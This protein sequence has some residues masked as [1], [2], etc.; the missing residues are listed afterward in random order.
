[1]ASRTPSLHMDHKQQRWSI[2]EGLG[3]REEGAREGK[4]KR[5]EREGRNVS[6]GGKR[7]KGRKEK[8][9]KGERLGMEQGKE[10]RGRGR[11]YIQRG[12][13]RAG[14]RR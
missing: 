11:R 2:C 8:G 9:E 6:S 14:R 5:N 12:K 3:T 7:R 10:K 1:M 13:G 4:D